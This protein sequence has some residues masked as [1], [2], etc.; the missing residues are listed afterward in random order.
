MA[1]NKDTKKLV[2]KERKELSLE[3]QETK[4]KMKHTLKVIFFLLAI[5]SVVLIMYQVGYVHGAKDVQ[6]DVQN[7]VDEFFE[8]LFQFEVIGCILSVTQDPSI[9]MQDMTL[10][11][12]QNMCICGYQVGFDEELFQ[13]MCV[14]NEMMGGISG[15]SISE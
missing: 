13:Q 10:D 4:K 2:K 3:Q 8:Y 7:E 11:D 14:E 1:K 5:V 12:V 15:N 6:E 9:L